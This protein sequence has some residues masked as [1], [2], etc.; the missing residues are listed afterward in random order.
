MRALAGFGLFAST[1]QGEYRLTPTSA[2]L[3]GDSMLK[4]YVRVWG[5]QLLGAG[6]KMLEMVQT[7]RIA[8]ELA[9]G[10]P[11]Y[12]YYKQNG[13]AGEL[14]VSYM[15]SVTDGQRHALL[16]CFDFSPYHHVVDIGGGRAS[17]LTTVVQDY[18]SIRGT[19]LDQPHMA[20]AIH[21]RIRSA[22][23]ADRC[24]FVGGSFFEGVPPGGDVYLI[25]SVLHDWHDEAVITI[26]KNIAA[27]LRP[28]SKLIIIEG[29]MDERDDVGKLLKVRDLEQMVWCGGRVRT[30][31]EFE[32]LLDQAG[33]VIEGTR[34]SKVSDGCLIIGRLRTVEHQ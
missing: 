30:R 11:A 32:H 5:E 27:Q 25:K 26:L 19:I 1:E 6:E 14:F 9:H 12:E 16:S 17:L 21:E 28:D 10:K 20:E 33:L 29:L 23:V 2:P 7:G 4:L 31:Q 34:P 18:P 22:N 13:E 3:V 24:A 8:F 15:N